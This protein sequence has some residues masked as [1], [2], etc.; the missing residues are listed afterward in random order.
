MTTGVILGSGGVR[1]LAHIGVLRALE[2]D[3][4]D[5][6]IIHG[7]SAGAIIGG[8]YAAGHS[9][10]E[11]M[12]LVDEFNAY[13]FI[14]FTNIGGG[15][16]KGRKARVFLEKHIGDASFNDLDVAFGVNALDLNAGEVRF[17]DEGDVVDAVH[18]SMAIP[19]VFRPVK[20]DGAYLLD[21][22]YV[23]P[24]PATNLPS[25]DEVYVV[26]VTPEYDEID[27]ETRFH[28]VVQSFF[29]F[30]QQ[31]FRDDHL[32]TLREDQDD[33]AIHHIEPDTSAWSILSFSELKDVIERGYEATKAATS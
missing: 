17:L 20:R 29:G 2:E 14:D 18:A 22:G 31:S 28:D 15:I 9:V 26:D 1:G 12:E 33:A 13:K 11:I 24:I 6:D 3:G 27:D 10:D 25:C 32:Q 8:L 19:G 5:I 21:A 30:V 16:L 4:V 7:S 23:D